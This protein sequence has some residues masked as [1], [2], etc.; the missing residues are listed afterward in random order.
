MAGVVAFQIPIDKLDA[1]IGET[2]GMGKSGE[3]YAIGSDRLFRS[4]SRFTKELGVKTTIVNPE[5]KVDTVAVKSARRG[6]ERHRHRRRLSRSALAFVM[7]ARHRAPGP[8]RRPQ[9]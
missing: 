6:Q 4:N 3:T 8:F 1:I 2:T 7:A 5:I 9:R